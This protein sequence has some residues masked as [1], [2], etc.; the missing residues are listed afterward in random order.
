MN[1]WKARLASAIV[2]GLNLLLLG[3]SER[4]PSDTSPKEDRPDTSSQ[5]RRLV[6]KKAPDFQGD[7]ALNGQPIKLSELQGKI[8]LLDF[9]ALWCGPCIGSLPHLI[10]LEDRYKSK[11]FEVVGVIVPRPDWDRSYGF[12]KKT[13][14]FMAVE[15]FTLQSQRR[16]LQDFAE[17]HKINYLVLTLAANDANRVLHGYNV[18][19]I[20]R[21]VLIDR[22]GIIKKTFSGGD[23]ATAMMIEQEIKILLGEKN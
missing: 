7:F 14:K 5:G 21:Q 3:C 6:D 23:P 1:R 22:N 10:E 9:W 20:P 13:G 12:D 11:G 18:A 8:V 4:M 19:G 17:Y 2:V 15:H 16:T